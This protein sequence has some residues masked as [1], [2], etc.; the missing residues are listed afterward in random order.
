MHEASYTNVANI[1]NTLAFFEDFLFFRCLM[2]S[3]GKSNWVDMEIRDSTARAGF[4]LVELLVVI[5]IIAVLIG[6][7]LP[8][9]QSIRE[10]ARRATCQNNLKQVVLAISLYESSFQHLPPGR[11]G[12]DDTGDQMAL[13]YCP[14]E[15]P[16]EEKTGASGFVSILPQIEQQA[17][18]DELDVDAGG[19]WNR[20]VDDLGWYSD[21][22]KY[23]GVKKHVSTYWCPSENGSRMSDAYYPVRAATSSYAFSNGTLGPEAPEWM[24]KFENDG[25]FLYRR[26]HPLRDIRDGLSTTFFVGEVVQPD[27]W[28]SSNVWTYALANADCLRSTSNPLNTRPGEGVVLELRNGAFASSHPGGGLFAFGDGHVGFVREQID[29]ATYRGLSTVSGREVVSGDD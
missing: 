21:S 18:S 5:S 19:L 8:A 15:L 1:P 14:P 27:T 26:V 20:D 3:Q 29:Q 6:M 17:L 24:T 16:S 9:I 11:I 4:T 2:N 23:Y 12:C 25:A 28:E 7:L 22:G 13:V 10:A